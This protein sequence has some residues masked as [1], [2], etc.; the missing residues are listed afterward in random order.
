MDHDTNERWQVR[1]KPREN[2]DDSMDP[3][4]GCTD[5]DDVS[6]DLLGIDRKGHAAKVL[7]PTHRWHNIRC[8][9]ASE[10]RQIA[11]MLPIAALVH[12]RRKCARRRAP[13]ERVVRSKEAKFF[14]LRAIQRCGPHRIAL[15][16][17][18]VVES[19]AGSSMRSGRASPDLRYRFAG[20]PRNQ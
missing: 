15:D 10:L 9:S 5:H 19:V 8:M 13:N 2:L 4:R 11:A 18:T 14:C 7:Y 3:A 17:R 16:A 1:R 20:G 6:H 12:R